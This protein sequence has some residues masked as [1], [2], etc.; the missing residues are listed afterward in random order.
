[1]DVNSI[2]TTTVAGPQTNTKGMS[3]LGQAAF[4]DLIDAEA[5]KTAALQGNGAPMPDLATPASVDSAIQSQDNSQAALN[6]NF[7][8]NAPD[9]F[10]APVEVGQTTEPAGTELPPKTSAEFNA[11]DEKSGPGT[12]LVGGIKGPQTV[13]AAKDEAERYAAEAKARDQAAT[14]EAQQRLQAHLAQQ[15]LQMQQDILRRSAE[16]QKAANMT[17]F[18]EDKSVPQK[19]LLGLAMGRPGGRDMVQSAMTAD[20]EMKK[21]KLAAVLEQHKMA[22]ASDQQLIQFY[23]EAQKNLLANHLAKVNMIDLTAQKILARYPQ[24]QKNASVALATEKANTM[25]AIADLATS[26]TSVSTEGSKTTTVTGK[27]AASGPK[28]AKE[29][30]KADA[31]KRLADETEELIKQGGLPTAENIRKINED[32]TSAN[33]NEEHARESSISQ[34]M[35][36]IGKEYAPSIVPRTEYTNVSEKVA[37]THSR[38]RTMVEQQIA[39]DLGPRVVGNPDLV[40]GEIRRRMPNADDPPAEAARKAGTIIDRS[41]HAQDVLGNTSAA[42]KIGAGDSARAGTA[43]RA[44]WTPV[45]QEARKW[46]IDHANSPIAKERTQAKA[47]NARLLAS[48]VKAAQ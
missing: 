47:I 7:V 21:A 2:P 3:K 17:S 23:D 38:L 10:A 16:Y 20:L 25:K 13:E 37:Q 14:M 43:P 27:V 28:D 5:A 48:K 15:R 42:Q 45:E 29:V 35:I 24:A 12:G 6:R 22:G 19:I 11:S 34:R 18:W 41:R 9:P 46:A 31:Q 30:I 36:N 33:R 44:Q 1:M 32:T 8:K 4:Q 39:D 26:A 40:N